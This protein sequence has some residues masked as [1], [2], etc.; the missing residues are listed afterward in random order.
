MSQQAVTIETGHEEMIHD[1]QMDYYGKR[2]ATAS[3]DRTIKIFDVIDGRHNLVA[4]LR[5]HE[6]PVWQVAWAHPKFGNLL[7]SCSYDRKVI[8][9]K[10]ES[11]NNWIKVHEDATSQGSV[12]SIGWAP[13]VFGLVLAAASA[14]GFIAVHSYQ[15]EQK[16]WHTARFHAHEGGVNA[17][18]WGPE[19]VQGSLLANQQTPPPV[20]RF[21][22]G[23]CDNR[24]VVWSYDEQKQSW[25]EQKVFEGNA[26]KHGDWVRD[27]A[28]APSLGLPSTTIASAS[29]DKTVAIW[30]EDPSGT[31][32]KSHVL[33]FE[34]KVWRV[35]WSVMGNILAVSQGDQKVSLW[36]EAL[37]G[38]WN[39]LSSLRDDGRELKTNE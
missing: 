4:H 10:E 14:D 28:W 18:S 5:G 8:I 7:A 30:T 15:A 23:G 27:V 12:N 22:S 26:N 3:S 39:N 19:T 35:S 16:F 24:V 36:K 32:K 17:V 33:P 1:A 21:V 31:F 9:W 34:H 29:E 13:H 37:D 2:L 11:Q 20:K 38:K 6:G 25:D